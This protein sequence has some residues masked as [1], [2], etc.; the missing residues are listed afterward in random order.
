MPSGALVLRGITG[1]GLVCLMTPAFSGCREPRRPPNI[2]LISLDACRADH[3]SAYGYS[4]KT[5]PFL[6]TLAARGVLFTNAFVNTL[7][8]PPSH[9]TMLTSLYQET[10]RV[11]YRERQG[12][13]RYRIP[14]EIT[15]LQEHLQRSGYTTLGVTGGGFMAGKFGYSRGFTAF[16]DRVKG[17]H[18]GAGRLV[19]MVRRHA[20]EG[21]PIFAFLH[22]YF[23]HS[24]YSPPPDY[25][26]LWGQFTGRFEP[27]SQNLLAMNAWEMR[28]TDE[29]VC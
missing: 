25:R 17:D 29:A 12:F 20:A 15:L 24:T 21:K 9:T 10:H 26:R 11:D 6:D 23:I 2:L 18:V 14:D 8:T 22:T 4:R 7:G 3:L 19:R 28:V 27:S 5:S 1:L 16:D 13:A